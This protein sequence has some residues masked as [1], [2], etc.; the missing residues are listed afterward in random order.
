[1]DFSASESELWVAYASS[2]CNKTRN[3]LFLYYSSW[4]K[5]IVSTLFLQYRAKTTEWADFMQNA[6]I[7]LLESIERFEHLRGVPFE[8]YAYKRI[9]GSIINGLPKDIGYSLD[10]LNTSQESTNEDEVIDFEGFLDSVLELAFSKLLEISSEYNSSFSTDPSRLYQDHQ[11]DARLQ[12]AITLLPQDLQFII[13]SHYNHFLTFTHISSI[14][15]L[16]KARVSQLHKEALTTLR[17]IYEE[18][19]N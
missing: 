1:M 6:S 12:K 11:E 16:S 18:N 19:S 3:H 4:A 8:A 7:A 5:K 15:G 10:D 9:K 17:M 2:R 13:N 14:L